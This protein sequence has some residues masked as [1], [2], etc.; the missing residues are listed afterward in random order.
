MSNELYHHG[1]LGMKWGIRR[2][3]NA[4]GTLTPK[5]KK[6]YDK[7]EK[8]YND[9]SPRAK[10]LAQKYNDDSPRVQKLAQKYADGSP[11]MKK[12]ERKYANDSPYMKKLERKYGN[13]SPRFKKLERKCAKYITNGMIIANNNEM[14]NM[15]IQQ[16]NHRATENAIRQANYMVIQQT[17]RIAMNA[18]MHA[19]MHATMHSINM[20]HHY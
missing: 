10:K 3:Q 2:Y 11:R 4:D 5:G 14:M 19:A 18:A 9:D 16:M 12:L 7:L 13:D 6:R 17:N 8:K 15:T 20:M 1:I